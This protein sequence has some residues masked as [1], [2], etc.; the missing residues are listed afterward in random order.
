MATI[1][2]QGVGTAVPKHVYNQAQVRQIVEGLFH[3][4]VTN[5]DRL[6]RVFDHLHIA[7]RHFVRDPEWYAADHGF[8]ELNQLFTEKATELSSQ[9]ASNVIAQT[10]IDAAQFAGVVAVTTTG[11]MTPSLDAVLL[12]EL[13][14]PLTCIRLPIVGL[15]CA[16]GVAGL[17]RAAE[18]SASCRGAP[19][20]FVAVEI[21]SATF[22]KN[23]TSKSNLIGT[24]I[25]ADGAAAV[26][27]GEGGQ[28]P[29][30]VGSFH[31]LFPDTYDIMGWDII[32]SGMK[33]RF[34]RDI[35]SF[36]RHHVPK[37]I[38]DSCQKWGISADEILSY[39]T[40]PGGAKVLEAFAEV[41]GK[42]KE[43]LASAYQVLR[44]YGNMSSAS[45]LFVLEDML[46][47]TR[48]ESGYALMS[49]LGPGFSSDQLLLKIS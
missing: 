5:F 29:E 11:M 46:R 27:V 30:I 3:E 24:S 42:P 20:L 36:V 38:A 4:R 35:P 17:A 13:N 6:L 41:I 25:F 49:A 18:L 34:S 15:G 40:H 1:R 45:I 21:C 48:L 23:D 47:N 31:Q 16:G 9:A 26:I 14:L 43:S 37:V 19:V 12:Q 22:Q 7:R 10:G 2:I 8:A 44:D 39:I 32:D 33:V 28:G